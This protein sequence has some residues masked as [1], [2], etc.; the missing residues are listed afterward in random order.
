SLVLG[1]DPLRGSRAVV[2][3]EELL[4]WGLTLPGIT[5]GLLAGAFGIMAAVVRYAGLFHIISD[6]L[7]GRAPGLRQTALDL[8]PRLPALFRLCVVSVAAGA[9][10]ALPVAAGLAAI[11]ATVLGR[12]DINYYLATRPPEWRVALVMAAGWVLIVGLPALWVAGR[13]ALALP[14]YLDGHQPLPAALRESWARTRGA[15]A[16]TARTL[17]LAVGAW[18][19]GRALVGAAYVALGSA[20]VSALGSLTRSLEPLVLA[21]AAYALGLIVLDAVI[22]FTGFAFVATVLT[23][24]YYEDTDLHAR[25]PPPVTLQELPAHVA[26]RIQAI[27]RPRTAVPVAALLLVVSAGASG[28]LIGRTPD[29]GPVIVTAH[30]GGPPPAPENTLAALERAIDAGADWAEI[31]VQ[32]T[33]DGTVVAVHDADLMRMAGDPR[34]IRATTYAELEGVVQRPDDGSPPAERR[35]AT[36]AEILDRS[37][38]RIGILIELKYYGADPELAG[39]VVRAVRRAG[40]SGEVR[41]MSLDYPAVRDVQRL[42]P[43]ISTGYVAAA[44]VGDLGRLPVDFIAVARN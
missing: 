18:L 43:R 10:L 22:A 38:D 30:R 7:R 33:R 28:A 19:L 14:A 24:A 16:R 17:G 29:P 35:V 15:A 13:S 3:N 23:K 40:M 5:W 25:A 27:L 36:L 12:Y 8:A 2:G 37:Q 41:V 31:D 6:D 9:A 42:A 44:A 21:T 26:A 39:A 4:A 32:R 34:R 1:W 11:K 20:A